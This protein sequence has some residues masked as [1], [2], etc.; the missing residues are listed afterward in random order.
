M[1]PLLGELTDAVLRI[2]ARPVLHHFDALAVAGLLQAVASDHVQL[3]DLV[4]VDGQ[5]H[6]DPILPGE[7]HVDVWR[8]RAITFSKLNLFKT[9]PKA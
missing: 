1:N 3:T 9:L 2:L 5:R 8:G 4:L 6:A 7:D